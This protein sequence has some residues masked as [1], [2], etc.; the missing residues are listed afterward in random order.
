MLSKSVLKF[1]DDS[2]DQR[3]ISCL[4]LIP[5]AAISYASSDRLVD[6]LRLPA[7]VASCF[8]DMLNDKW[9]IGCSLE[10]C[11]ALQHA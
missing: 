11:E 9:M 4:T 8:R 10:P 2:G 6:A 7:A 1:F 3:Y 5:P